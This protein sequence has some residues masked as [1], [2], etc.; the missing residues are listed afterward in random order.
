MVSQTRRNQ[1]GPLA[2][3]WPFTESSFRSSCSC[4]SFEVSSVTR[5]VTGFMCLRRPPASRELPRLSD[6]PPPPP[7]PHPTPTHPHTHPSTS[8]QRQGMCAIGVDPRCTGVCGAAC[9][10]ALFIRWPSPSPSYCPATRPRQAGEAHRHSHSTLPLQMGV[11]LGC[12]MGAFMDAWVSTDSRVLCLPVFPRVRVLRFQGRR[13]NI[14]G[15][16]GFDR[17]LSFFH[18]AEHGRYIR[19]VTGCAL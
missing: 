18:A 7:L 5:S 4:R 19:L 8:A 17:R 10:S 11:L 12:Q 3:C 13:H 16:Q 9:P 14:P 1:A 6:Q 2:C 15:R